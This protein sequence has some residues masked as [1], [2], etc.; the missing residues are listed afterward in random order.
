MSNFINTLRKTVLI[1]LLFCAVASNA[2]DITWQKCIGTENTDEASM[3][4]NDDEGNLVIVGNEAHPDFTGVLRNYTIVAKYNIHGKELWRKYHDIPYQTLNP[5][6]DY[7]LL[8]HFYTVEGGQKLINI[9][10]NINSRF[11]L[12]KILDSNGDAYN[13]ED[14]ISS[15]FTV[16]R[17]NISSYA[18]SECNR[19]AA[20]CY[21]PDSLTVL[22]NI[23]IEDTTHQTFGHQWNYSWRQNVRTGSID[24]HYDV[25]N[26]DITTDEDGNI[27]LLTQIERWDFQHC[28]DCGDI[29]VNA[30]CMI[31]KI[32]NDANLV[33]SYKI[34]TVNAVVSNMKFV[35]CK[36]GQIIV[37][38]DDINASGTEVLSS[39]Y[40]LNYDLEQTKTYPLDKQYD[41][42]VADDDNNVYLSKFLWDPNLY[43]FDCRVTKYSVYGIKIWSKLYGGKQTE[44]PRGLTT[45]IDG[46]LA[47]IAT[48]ESN[49]GDVT[50][51]HGGSDIWLVKIDGSPVI[52]THDVAENQ[53][54]VFP[55]PTAGFIH[56]NGIEEAVEV[57]IVDITGQTVLSTKMNKSDNNTLTT[58]GLPSGCYFLK[59]KSNGNTNNYATVKVIKI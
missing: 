42:A 7:T 27:Y 13:Y 49:N 21:G 51:N 30:Y 57:N 38:I 8:D 12:Y 28:T 46:G 29:F 19:T 52:G 22:R 10:L 33:K 3:V 41:F 1:C 37:K 6:I 54:S 11:I 9:Y 15:I 45:T 40:H 14:Q 24:G 48:T 26:Q 34:K 50:G 35:K 32:D 18:T 16:D 39:V 59:I 4:F 5:P 17:N 20:A 44:F 36:D 23:W 2:Q 56:I 25:N 43:T 53:V 31:I 47:M 58:E 55:N